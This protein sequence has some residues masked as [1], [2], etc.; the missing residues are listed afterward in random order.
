[1]YIQK[2]YIENFRLLAETE[3]LL[4]KTA[5]VIVGRNNTGK[6]SLAEVI[7][8]FLGEKPKIPARGFFERF[9]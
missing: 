8:R 2:I 6:T 3:L 1:M 5:T 9:V 4:E 7:R